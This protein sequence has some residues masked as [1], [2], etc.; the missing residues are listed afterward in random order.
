MKQRAFARP[1]ES[2]AGLDEI[3]PCA[4]CGHRGYRHQDVLWDGLVSEWALS[5]AETAYINRQQGTQCLGCGC[6]IRSIAL[7]KAICAS[8]GFEGTLT[9]LIATAPSERML[10]V[11]EAGTLNPWLRQFPGH[12]FGSYPQV[13]LQK[14]SLADAS[15]DLIIHSDTLEHVPD[16][17]KAL[18]E[19]KR[20][21][22]PNGRAVFT[23]PIILG[24]MSQ[25]R[26]GLASSYHGAPG[27]SESD[28]V[29]HSEFGADFWAMVMQAG[30][31]R[32]EMISF[33]YPAG[34]AIVAR[35]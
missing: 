17:M 4:V 6:N 3:A 35:R 24:R 21:L 31:T 15:V 13:D 8:A 26:D 11:N 20:V 1:V 34:I 22:V 27:G 18:A 23:V 2:L 14:L 32:C 12:V 9:E 30:F 19:M 7:A 10:E 16:P 29:V 5:E 28:L 25:S 33:D